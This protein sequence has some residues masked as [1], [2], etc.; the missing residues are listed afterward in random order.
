M[1]KEAL[2]TA[3][4]EQLKRQNP[5]AKDFFLEI[6]HWQLVRALRNRFVEETFGSR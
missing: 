1:E 6:P 4:I 3:I 5:G 2:H